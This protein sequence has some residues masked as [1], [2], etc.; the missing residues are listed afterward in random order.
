GTV[1][2][3]T[4]T[5]GSGSS[6]TTPSTTQPLVSSVGPLASN[7]PVSTPS[8]FMTTD[9]RPLQAQ[10]TGLFQSLVGR[11]PSAD[12]LN[13]LVALI[14]GGA[15]EGQ[16]KEFIFATPDYFQVRGMGTNKGFLKALYRDVFGKAQAKKQARDLVR[17]RHHVS[18]ITVIDGVLRRAGL[19]T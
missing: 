6:T 10:A 18:R 15:T 11:P 16:L 12:Q 3:T 17:L 2:K 4:T 5:T 9:L 1:G 19:L 7:S 8:P 13:Q 14:Q